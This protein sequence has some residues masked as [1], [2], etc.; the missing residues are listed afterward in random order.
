ML[1]TSATMTD[2]S[3][4][5][6]EL[7]CNSENKAN[8]RSTEPFLELYLDLRELGMSFL[9]NIALEKSKRLRGYISAAKYYINGV[10]LFRCEDGLI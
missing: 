3:K 6:E 1:E 9:S 7:W 10:A 8:L 4:S 5:L 2:M